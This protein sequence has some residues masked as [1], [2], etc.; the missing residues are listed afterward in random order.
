MLTFIT[1]FCASVDMTSPEFVS[2]LNYIHRFLDIKVTNEQ[3]LVYD[4]IVWVCICL[5]T[6]IIQLMFNLGFCIDNQKR[7]EVPL[8]NAIYDFSLCFQPFMLQSS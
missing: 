7:E 4:L 5:Y 1:Q 8:A 2:K 3:G 6:H